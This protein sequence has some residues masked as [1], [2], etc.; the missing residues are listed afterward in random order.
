MPVKNN[1]KKNIK[2]NGGN[3]G[4]ALVGLINQS[5]KLGGSMFN[6]AKGVMNMPSD[7]KNAIPPNEKKAPAQ[8]DDTPPQDLPPFNNVN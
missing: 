2:Q 4:N 7:L 3:F 8:A 5:L 1:K 6:A